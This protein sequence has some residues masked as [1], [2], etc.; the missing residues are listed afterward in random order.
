M[1]DAA[2]LKR[3]L[4]IVNQVAPEWHLSAQSGPQEAF[5]ILRTNKAATSGGYG[6]CTA[7]DT[8]G[9]VGA[10][11]IAKLVGTIN[12]RYNVSRGLGNWQGQE[13]QGLP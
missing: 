3:R 11:R 7:W 5:C 4:A 12:S 8:S 10:P 6:T 2:L 13:R 9:G 1:T